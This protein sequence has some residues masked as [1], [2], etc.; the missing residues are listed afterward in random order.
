MKVTR[1]G[2]AGM[3][4]VEPRICRDD[5]GFFFESFHA[6]R[7]E[8][9]GI[10]AQFVQDNCS[11]SSAGVLR[12]M[13]YQ[14]RQ[15]QGHLVTLTEGRIFDVGVDLRPN[16]PTFGR[17]HG[18]VLTTDPSRQLYLPPGV[19]HGFYTLSEQAAIWYKCTGFYLPGDEGGL[20]WNDPDVGIR[21]PVTDPLLNPRDTT[22]P[23]LGDI[24]PEHLPQLV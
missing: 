6:E 1:C 16:S 21:W 2:I 8:A 24:A 23:R 19:A 20:L 14:I 15:P 3:L 5:R 9:E 22:L 10:P 11:V 12:G 17:W 4:L 18:E 7:Y 13:H